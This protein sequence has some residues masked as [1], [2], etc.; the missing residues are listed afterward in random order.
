MTRVSVI[1]Y[2]LGNIRSVVNGCSRGQAEVQ[3][4]LNGDELLSQDP[5]RIILPGVGAAGA[6]LKNLREKQFDSALQSLVIENNIPFLGICVGMQVLADEC[7]EFGN[8]KGLG[9]IPGKVDRILPGDNNLRVPHMGWN[10]LDITNRDDPVFGN[11][12]GEDVYF[13]H[14]YAMECPQEYIA[15]TTNYGNP[16]ISAIR[17][18]HIAAVQFHPEKSAA[19]GNA[20]LTAFLNA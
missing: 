4:A 2:G 13:V 5:D 20:L 19:V 1:E 14:S 7:M 9:W 12:D 15:A 6:A 8:H 11:L 16:F 18:G 17:R 10:T 3:I